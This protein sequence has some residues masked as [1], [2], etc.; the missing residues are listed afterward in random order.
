MAGQVTPQPKDRKT[1]KEADM[2]YR[3]SQ[4]HVLEQCTPVGRLNFP[5]RTTL[6]A[7]S[8]RRC[9]QKDICNASKADVTS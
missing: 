4:K 7:S 8:F 6:F 2:T 9:T 5:T 3:R 1:I